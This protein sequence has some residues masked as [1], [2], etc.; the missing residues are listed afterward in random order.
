[1]TAHA[2]VVEAMTPRE[3]LLACRDEALNRLH[4]MP[5]GWTRD[6]LVMAADIANRVGNYPAVSSEERE[7]LEAS[8][9]TAVTTCNRLLKT[10]ET[11]ANL[12]GIEPL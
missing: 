11:C 9:A 2:Q 1:M 10:A 12:E 5:E 6:I 4:R 3:R 8:Q 7:A